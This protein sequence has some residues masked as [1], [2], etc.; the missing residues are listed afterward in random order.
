M[1]GL[2]G[3]NHK[4]YVCRICLWGYSSEERL[5]SHKPYCYHKAQ[6]VRMPKPDKAIHSFGKG[7][8]SH[9]V[10]IPFVIY[11]DFETVLAIRSR[12]ERNGHSAHSETHSLL[13]FLQGGLLS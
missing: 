11:A 13:I 5:E 8:L 10:K 1:S 4:K 6:T 12:G 9:T 7:N 3:K 2:F